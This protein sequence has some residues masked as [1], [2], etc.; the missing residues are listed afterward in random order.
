MED[1]SL[2]SVSG[3][4]SIR[5]EW[6]PVEGARESRS[7]RGL[8]R[9]GGAYGGRHWED[10]FCVAPE[11]AG[12]LRERGGRFGDMILLERKA[13]DRTRA[14]NPNYFPGYCKSW[15]YAGVILIRICQRN[16]H[17]KRNIY[18]YSLGGNQLKTGA[19]GCALDS[20]MAL[21]ENN[22]LARTKQRIAGLEEHVPHMKPK[23][24]WSF[25]AERSFE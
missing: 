3:S 23:T 19:S 8:G 6:I 16:V 21:M 11:A 9:T 12:T 13:K 22:N 17:K 10:L 1:G 7:C 4:A 15:D 2:V 14:G 25:S 24:C 20:T 18:I 5:E